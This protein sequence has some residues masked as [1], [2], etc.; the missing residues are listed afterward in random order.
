MSTW[1]FDLGNTRLKYAHRDAGGQ[2]GAMDSL[3]HHAGAD[4]SEL[5][6]AVRGEHA[7]ISAVASPAIRAAV[8]AEL[9]PRFARIS[10]ART[11]ARCDGLRIAYAAPARLGVDR[12]LSMLAARPAGEPVLICGIGT[13]LTLDLL[14]GQGRHHGGRIA[15]SPTLMRES[16]SARARQ[17]PATGGDYVE[18]A[19][20]TVDALASGCEGAALALIDHSRQAAA[21]WL[22]TPPRL[23]LHGG[24]AAALLSRIH[25]AESRP[26]LVL[27]GLARY[28]TLGDAIPPPH[29]R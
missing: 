16:L 15:P 10:F 2:L 25:D 4:F 14:D 22:G 27:E 23:W 6:Q 13:A 26:R 7:W 9:G 24:G 3:G 21:R 19:G 1:L 8:L 18:F 29:D 12:F 20:D 5:P 11:A 17:L 28:A